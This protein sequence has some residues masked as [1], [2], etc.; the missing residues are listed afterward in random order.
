M[1][2]DRGVRA[3][4]LAS[5]RG[6]NFQ[7]ILQA[8]ADGRLPGLQLEQLI[9][10]RQ[11]S[12]AELL[13]RQAGVGVQILDYARYAQ[14]QEFEADL[15]RT[16]LAAEPD[17]ILALGFMRILPA[18]VTERFPHRII[19]I[20]PALLPAF[21]G[22]QAQKQAFDYGVRVTGA[23]VHFVD[24]GVDTGP[25]ILQKALVIESDWSLADLS[26]ALLP[27]EHQLIVEATSCFVQG[28]LK[29]TGRKVKIEPVAD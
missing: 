14:R 29:V 26:A 12:G 25:I 2:T 17:L 8:Q 20:H 5:G 22:M 7:A 19:N 24:A 10:D 13:A 9:V 4:V 28:R 21:P 18:S 6:S 23:T 15:L 27:M 16:L 3:V 11:K 1:P